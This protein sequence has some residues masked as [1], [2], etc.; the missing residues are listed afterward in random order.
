ML[1]LFT[2]TISYFTTFAFYELCD[3]PVY[4]IPIDLVNA[5]FMDV[6]VFLYLYSIKCNQFHY[7][8]HE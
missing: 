7:P 6:R 8:T 1:S 2:H 3:A 4:K 5:Y